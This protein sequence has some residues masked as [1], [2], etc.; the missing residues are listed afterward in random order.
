MSAS[1][2]EMGLV[3]EVRSTSVAAGNYAKQTASAHL[4]S[5]AGAK[6]FRRHG[7]QTAARP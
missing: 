3:T 1:D 5:R 4:S 6:G 2:D 7:F